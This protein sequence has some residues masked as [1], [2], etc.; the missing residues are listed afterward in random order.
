MHEAKH[1]H[2]ARAVQ[3]VGKQ[4]ILAARL[5]CAQQT[6]SKMLNYEIPIS[7]EHAIAIDRATAGRV[8]KELLRPDLFSVEPKVAEQKQGRAS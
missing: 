8:P 6:V 3:I 4:E 5:R 2:V 7:A 1:P